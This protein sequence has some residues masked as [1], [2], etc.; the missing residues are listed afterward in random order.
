M[1]GTALYGFLFTMWILMILG[2]GL[3]V[4]VLGP[5]SFSGFGEFDNLLSSGVKGIVAILLVVAWIFIL[6]KM[7]NWVF[8]KQLKS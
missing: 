7:K 4:L 1:S 5:L 2:G 6:S 8:R 3:A